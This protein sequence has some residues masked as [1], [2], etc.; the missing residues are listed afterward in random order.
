[1]PE[2]IPL[3]TSPSMGDLGWASSSLHPPPILLDAEGNLLLPESLRDALLPARLQLATWSRSS[4][5]RGRE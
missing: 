5:T 3:Q 4:F 2:A 1:L